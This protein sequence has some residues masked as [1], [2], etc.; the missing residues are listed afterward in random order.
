MLQFNIVF[1]ATVENATHH[2]NIAKQHH[3]LRDGTS[4]EKVVQQMLWKSLEQCGGYSFS[5]SWV[6]L[7]VS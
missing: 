7:T 4:R 2:I 1:T 6:V 3:Q 5:K